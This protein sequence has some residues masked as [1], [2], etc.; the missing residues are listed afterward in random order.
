M[1]EHANNHHATVFVVDDDPSVR[2]SLRRLIES[3]GLEVETY[4]NAESFLASC[5]GNRAGCLVLDVR[6]PGLSGLELQEK[7]AARRI[8]VPII[9][10][11]G[12]GDVPMTARAMKAGAVD[13][14]QK[15]FNEQELLDAISRALE[16]DTRQRRETA[17]RDEIMSRVSTLTAR[18]RDVFS[19]V[20]AG[21]I[22]KEIAAE[23]GICEKT[24]KV[25]RAR[26]MEKM[27]ADSLAELVLFAQVAGYTTKVP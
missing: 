13:F 5:D 11:T 9:F 10:I 16:Q 1:N 15:P 3:V 12:F 20:A 21:R 23:F 22:N 2:R 8:Q 4:E 19:R 17:Q 26:V 7:L 14:I 18:E 27:K 25:H 24:I 6:M